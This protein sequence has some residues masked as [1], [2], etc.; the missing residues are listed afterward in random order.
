MLRHLTYS[1]GLI[2][3]LLV[4]PLRISS[5][6]RSAALRAVSPITKPL[7]TINR[8]LENDWISLRQIP[9]LLQQRRDLQNQV[10]TLQ[11]QLLEEEQLAKE[12]VALRQELGITGITQQQPKILVHVVVQGLDPADRT[13]TIDVGT[14]QGIS[15]G[16]AA[17][18][19]G[20]LIGRVI[21]TNSNTATVRLLTS[22]HSL[23]QARIASNQQKGLLIG[24][25]NSVQLTDVQQGTAPAADSTVETSGLGGSLPAGILIGTLGQTLSKPS[26]L[27]QSFLVSLPYDPSTVSNFFILLTATG[28]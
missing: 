20:S 11:R 3:L 27:S 9:S 12:N 14:N 16:Q 2:L 26:N 18:Y 24:T 22:N 6:L 17:I 15:K 19:E 13:L 1:T 7:V 8:T 5:G 25:G 21:Q 23:I 4:L 10:V 28:S